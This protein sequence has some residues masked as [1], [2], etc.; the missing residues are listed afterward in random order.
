M[1]WSINCK[2]LLWKICIPDFFFGLILALC[3][4]YGREDNEKH[5]AQPLTFLYS[6]W[7][8]KL[9]MMMIQNYLSLFGSQKVKSL[10]LGLSLP[11][12][13]SS[14][15]HHSSDHHTI[16][17]SKRRKNHISL[18]YLQIYVF[19]Y[20][21][22]FSNPEDKIRK[23]KSGETR[24]KLFSFSFLPSFSLS[25]PPHFLKFKQKPP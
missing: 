14:L 13:L 7:F 17:K 11:T 12:S 25:F 1:E 18:V 20:P 6:T 10:S 21:W 16:T 24:K 5:G 22:L 3:S 15:N 8:P 9:Y 4:L 23:I 19:L 2:W